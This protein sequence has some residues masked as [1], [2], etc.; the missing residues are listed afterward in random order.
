MRDIFYTQRRKDMITPNGTV[1]R[2]T[3]A[4][5][6]EG[7]EAVI[8]TAAAGCEWNVTDKD[9]KQLISGKATGENGEIRIVGTFDALPWSAQSPVLYTLNIKLSDGEDISDRFG[10][11]Y[12]SCD[13]RYIYLNGFPFYMRAYIRGAAAHEHQNNCGL[14]EFDF[15]K[16]NILAAKSY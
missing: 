8:V 10:F 3:A 9:K 7:F 12:F 4:K 5:P 6:E 15:Y 1:L 14:S 16:K 2:I 11:R 13:E